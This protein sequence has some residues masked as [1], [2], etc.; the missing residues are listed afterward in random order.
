MFRI[1]YCGGC[2]HG[3]NAMQ[4]KMIYVG[5]CPE[6][7]HKKDID[8]ISFGWT[9]DEHKE[10]RTG[11]TSVAQ[12]ALVAVQQ[13]I[14][15]RGKVARLARVTPDH[16]LA[17]W[18]LQSPWVAFEPIVIAL[19]DEVAEITLRGAEKTELY[20]KLLKAE[21]TMGYGIR[22]VSGSLDY[23]DEWLLEEKKKQEPP[24]EA[25]P[26]KKLLGVPLAG[27][28][29]WVEVETVE[30]AYAMGY[31]ATVTAKPGTKSTT[32]YEATT[33]SELVE[34]DLGLLQKRLSCVEKGWEV[35]D[36]KLVSTKKGNN[37]YSCLDEQRLAAIVTETVDNTEKDWT[38]PGYGDPM[39][40]W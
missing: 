33:R 25:K 9:K 23:L 24:K 38:H 4:E 12:Q 32:Q 35:K 15:T 26:K 29:R 36:G 1:K 19:V 16:L 5:C 21:R 30:Q 11:V 27:R 20:D 7:S 17:A 40:G 18:L 34:Y 2:T 14:D 6:F 22:A 10:D 37:Q 39:R 13:G 3:I 28:A 8:A 31:I